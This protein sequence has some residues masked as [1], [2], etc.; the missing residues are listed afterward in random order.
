MQKKVDVIKTNVRKV[1]KVSL[2]NNEKYIESQFIN[3][4]VKILVFQIS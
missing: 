1:I 2:E 4:P 3:Q